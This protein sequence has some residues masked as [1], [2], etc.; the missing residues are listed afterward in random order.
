MKLT[1]RTLTNALA[2][3]AVAASAFAFTP[4][5]AAGDGD[6]STTL[7]QCRKGKVWD[8][9]KKKCVVVKSNLL[10]DNNLYEAARDLAF[11]GRYDEAIVTL[12]YASNKS[13]PRV[14]NYLGY[15]HR[16]AGRIDVG[17]GYYKE[18]LRI[19]P[20]YTLVRSYMGEAFLQ[21]G[22]LASAREQLVEI[23]K[24]CGTGCAEYAELKKQIDAYK[25]N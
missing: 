21:K 2:A 4:V 6:S 12:S 17:M 5:Y 11:T 24:R 13:D 9:S 20:D 18:A 10:D 3:T 15:S 23:E 14:L 1:S 22:D 19:D 25:V 7:P 8:K 16:K